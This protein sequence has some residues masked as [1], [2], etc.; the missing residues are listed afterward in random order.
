MLERRTGMGRQSG[1]AEIKRTHYYVDEAGDPILFGARRKILV[2]SEGCSCFFRL[3]LADVEESEKLATEGT[4][5]G[6]GR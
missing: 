3:G 6:K 2:G 4:T 1:S 5:Q